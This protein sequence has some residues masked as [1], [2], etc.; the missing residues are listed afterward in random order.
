MT[1]EEAIRHAV[2]TNPAIGEAAANRRATEH[3]LRQS[4]G[5]L[6]PQVKMSG[7]A[8]R[9][10]DNRL[11]AVGVS[12]TNEWKTGREG[13][14]V[15]SQTLFDGLSSINDIY[16]QMARTEG[17][18]YR[19]HERSE[20]VALE[21]VEAY[22]DILR[23][24]ESL[25][26]V[27][28][29]TRALRGIAGKVSGRF[30]GGRAGL[31]DNEQ[32]RERLRGLQAMEAEYAIRLDEARSAFRR[33]VGKEPSGLR[34]P[35]RL[36]G[37][38]T[39]REAALNQTLSGNPTINAAKSD[40]IANRRNFDAAAGAH[41]PR[42]ALEG[43]SSIGVDTS[44]VYGRYNQSSVRVTAEMPIYSGGSDSAR[45]SAYAERVGESEMRLS[46]LQRAALQQIDKAWA[47]RAASGARI[48]ALS[49]Q[50]ASA[51]GVVRAYQS[52]YEG[53]NRALLDLLNAHNSVL[54]ARLSLAS[55]RSI[56]VYSDY[57][58][59]AAT[60][61]L[62]SMIAIQPPVEARVTPATERSLIPNPVNRDPGSVPQREILP[63]GIY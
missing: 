20:I 16:R 12:G 62:L 39:T 8:G 31:G 11:D 22:L 44:S 46:S 30:Q 37:L 27:K 54:S 19:T 25:S 5:A 21:S 47:V 1:L 2:R 26:A 34:M 38:P 9:E 35:G 61:R 45:R 55:A 10:I 32:A 7:Y 42:I 23:Y 40:V 49:S 13:S 18:A 29:T 24:S 33:S 57:Q 56:A 53:G 17:A 59:A 60:G 43:R 48:T 58:L 28:E 36:K 3:E 4:Q 41:M 15:F 63:Y 50:V 51:Q 14:I 52:D 6:L